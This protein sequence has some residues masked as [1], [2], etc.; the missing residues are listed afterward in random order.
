MRLFWRLTIVLLCGGLLAACGGQSAPPTTCGA[1]V[2]L[3]D[4]RLLRQQ[5]GTLTLLF[6]ITAPDGSVDPAAPP[7]F[8]EPL[9]VRINNQAGDRLLL[10]RVF[11]PA[12][13]VCGVDNNIPGAEGRLAAACL[14]AVPDGD[15]NDPL[16]SG[17]EVTVTI[18]SDSFPLVLWRLSL[19]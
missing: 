6:E 9:H 2:C 16:P 5:P 15:F 4:I 11:D 19:P 3:K 17:E 12:T 8:G 14:T 1:Q 10:E 18:Y 13:L 7:A